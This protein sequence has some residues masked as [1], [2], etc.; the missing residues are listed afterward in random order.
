MNIFAIVCLVLGVSLAFCSRM[1]IVHRHRIGELMVAVGVGN[2]LGNARPPRVG[3]YMG[4]V[5]AVLGIGL[6][7]YGIV[8]QINSGSPGAEKINYFALAFVTLSATIAYASLGGGAVGIARERASEDEQSD[9][10]A[11]SNSVMEGMAW[12]ESL[13]SGGAAF[14]IANGALAL[15]TTIWLLVM[16]LPVFGIQ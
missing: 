12:R 5:Q 4:V 13:R 11:E 14:L 8:I 7:V 15:L 16:F 10:S 6:V 9:G 3:A 1:L 2:A